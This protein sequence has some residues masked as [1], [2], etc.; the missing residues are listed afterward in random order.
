VS[1][2]R[3]T[4]FSDPRAALQ[5]FAFDA[6]VVSVFPDMIQRSV[7]GYGTTIAMTGLLAGRFS[8]PDTCCYDLGCS[9]GATLLAMRAHVQAPRC[10]LVGI[11]NS[12]A[13][14]ARCRELLPADAEPPVRIE[15]GDIRSVPLQPASVVALNFTLQ[16]VPQADRT[17]LL[18]RIYEALL[19]GGILI[20][21]E[22]ICFEDPRLDALTI[23]LYH[24][25]KRSNGYSELEI[26][27]KRDALENVLVP[28]TLGQHRQRLRDAG[29]QSC[30]VWFQC[31]NFASLLALK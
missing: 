24:D 5:P 30:D 21:S 12:A 2:Q 8:Q 17:A 28:E 1:E 14:V 25:F 23:E 9:L 13:M 4:L 27:G 22:K 16:F 7:P 18:A 31:M 3:D 11:D 19:P 26:A 15:Q 20:L 6:A 29:F 10:E